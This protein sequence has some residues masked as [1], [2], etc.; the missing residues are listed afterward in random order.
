MH[1]LARAGR[2]L[3]GG[4]ALALLLGATAAA[5]AV[6]PPPDPPGEVGISIGDATVGERVD[7]V[8]SARF[9]V[10]L[11]P[12]GAVLTRPV[13]VTYR[14]EDGSATVADGDY[15]P[16]SGALTFKPNLNAQVFTI[17][18]PVTDDHVAELDETFA[19]RLSAAPGDEPV[20]ADGQGAGLIRGGVTAGDTGGSDDYCDLNPGDPR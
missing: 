9:T 18:V 3:A 20:L 1:A 7:G 5:A 12:R 15:Q 14:T 16:V 19:V 10:R 6:A 8:A 11:L 2:L 13:T 17:A 4:L